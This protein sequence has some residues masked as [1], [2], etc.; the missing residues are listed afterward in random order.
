MN[1]YPFFLTKKKS[2]F[3][4]TFNV[5]RKKNFYVINNFTVETGKCHES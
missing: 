2:N 3:F 1:A 4:K 5:K